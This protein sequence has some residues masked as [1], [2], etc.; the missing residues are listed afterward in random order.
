MATYEL[1]WINEQAKQN[2][3]LFINNCEQNY[4]NQIQDTAEKLVYNHKEKPIVLLC[5]PSSSGKT[6]SAD[7]LCRAISKLGIKVNYISMD[8]YYLSRGSYEVPWDDEN[9][10]YDFESPLC[11][12]L[13]LLHEH[14]QKLTEGKQIEVPTFDFELKQRTNEVKKLSLSNDSM[15]VIEGIHAFNDTLMGGLEQKATGVYISLASSL[16]I[17]KSIITPDQLRFL[18]RAV[19][20][21]NFRGASVETTIKQWKS[22]RRGERI[23]IDPYK[24]FAQHNIDSYLP[25][26]TLILMDMLKNEIETK[27]NE[28]IKAGL[29]SICDAEKLFCSINYKDYMP[30]ASVLHEFVG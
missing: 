17:G 16:N 10:V 25:Y 3:K 29:G 24:S 28:L 4:I 26:E 27:E 19:R 6:T 23:Y 13:P 14:L 20:D 22:V 5:G 2:T 8:D 7:R 18:R 12:D 9:G 1:K 11:M 15:V 21:A 30:E